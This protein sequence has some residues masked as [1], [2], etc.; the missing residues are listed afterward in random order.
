MAQGSQVSLK[1]S[2]GSQKLLQEVPEKDH[3]KEGETL[4]SRKQPPTLPP[5]TLTPRSKRVRRPSKKCN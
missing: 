4:K 3:K 2:M 5:K 1:Q